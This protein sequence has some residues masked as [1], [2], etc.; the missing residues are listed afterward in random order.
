MLLW[1]SKL[2]LAVQGA[3]SSQSTAQGIVHNC[4]QHGQW[5]EHIIGTR[6]YE[7][8]TAIAMPCSWLSRAV[9]D[10]RQLKQMRTSLLQ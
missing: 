3:C 7:V 4:I 1:S 10:S 5:H 8:S 6:H 9:K 2:Q